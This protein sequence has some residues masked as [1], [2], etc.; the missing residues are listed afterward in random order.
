MTQYSV[1]YRESCNNQA[2]GSARILTVC[3][4]IITQR[5][6]IMNRWNCYANIVFCIT[7]LLKIICS[8]ITP[9][10]ISLSGT[11]MESMLFI[12]KLCDTAQ[13]W[14]S[15]S[16]LKGIVS[17]K[18]SYNFYSPDQICIFLENFFV[19]YFIKKFSFKSEV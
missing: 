1:M 15:N 10:S 4:A 19:I 5:R 11:E 7:P 9:A 8:H 18:M 13:V 12:E 6:S 3:S 16:V 14:C 17:S 2:T